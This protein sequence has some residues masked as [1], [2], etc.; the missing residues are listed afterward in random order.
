MKK[1]VFD[2]PRDQA[3]FFYL[4]FKYHT[5]NGILSI[6]PVAKYIAEV[7]TQGPAFA[8]QVM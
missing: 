1:K 3:L 8:G 4:L 2:N 5:K 6:E 7:L